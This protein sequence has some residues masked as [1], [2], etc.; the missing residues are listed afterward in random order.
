MDRC[1]RCGLPIAVED[2][3][4]WVFMYLST[5]FLTG[6]LLA[7]MFL[8]RPQWLGPGRMILFAAAMLLILG[9]LPVRKSL[10]L[11]IDYLITLRWDNPAGR[12]LRRDGE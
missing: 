3:N 4:T 12:A 11:A 2:G 8:I 7:L 6:V 1:P 10:A 5:A 9:T